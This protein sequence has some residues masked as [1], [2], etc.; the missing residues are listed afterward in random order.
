MTLCY[1]E[2]SA[3]KQPQEAAA[4]CLKIRA[5]ANQYDTNTVVQSYICADVLFFRR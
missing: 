5:S 1:S 2:G 3:L 4:I